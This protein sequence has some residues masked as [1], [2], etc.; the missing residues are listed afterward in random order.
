MENPI[1]LIYKFNNDAGLLANGYDDFLESSFQIE[2]ALEGFDLT[3]LCSELNLTE[4]LGP[5]DVSRVLLNTLGSTKDNPFKEYPKVPDVDRLDKACDAVIY[6]VGSMAK[7]GLNPHQITKAL[8]VV[9]HANQAKL[10]MPTD[11]YGKLCKPEGFVPPEDKLQ[12]I[13]DERS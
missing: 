11:Q 13:L 8:N 5:K 4:T 3:D 2:E 10:H 6:A 7:L 12:L 1:K 9:M